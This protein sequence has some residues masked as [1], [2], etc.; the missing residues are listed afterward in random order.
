MDELCRFKNACSGCHDSLLSSIGHFRKGEDHKGLECF[1][2]S[3][4]DLEKLPELFQLSG[5]P[6][7]TIEKLAPV[8]RS[9]YEYMQNQDIVGMTDL[10]EFTLCSMVKE[11][12]EGCEEK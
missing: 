1:L 8:A 12:I 3:L 6:V 7:E 10:M 2:N 5:K 9:L 4:D 11:C